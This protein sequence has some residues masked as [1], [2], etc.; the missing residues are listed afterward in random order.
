MIASFVQVVNGY[1]EV[2]RG[3]NVCHDQEVLTRGD[4]IQEFP[5]IPTSK[6]LK[7]GH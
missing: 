2:Y 1:I 7:V 5:D 6:P 3:P 4:E